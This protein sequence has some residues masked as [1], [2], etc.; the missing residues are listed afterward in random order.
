MSRPSRQ[1]RPREAQPAPRRSGTGSI[2]PGQGVASRQGPKTLR[3]PMIIPLN[4]CPKDLEVKTQ[5]FETSLAN[6]GQTNEQIGSPLPLCCCAMHL[7]T[8][9]CSRSLPR[10]KKVGLVRR[11]IPTHSCC[12]HVDT[13]GVAIALR[14]HRN[15]SASPLQSGVLRAS[16]PAFVAIIRYKVGLP[17][18]TPEAKQAFC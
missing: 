7:C 17:Q 6:L 4:F 18:V 5:R 8:V 10:Q 13:S 1:P 3:A 14:L 16:H 12:K 9:E 15:R 2:G 11:N